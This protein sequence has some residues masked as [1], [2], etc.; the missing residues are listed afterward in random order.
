MTMA[1]RTAFQTAMRAAA[2]EMLTA[3]ALDTGRTLQ[4]YRARPASIF[5]PTAFVDRVHERIAYL[6]PTFIQR[7]PQVDVIV[8]HGLYDSGDA[9][10]QRD[11]FIDAFLDWA[12]DRYHAAGTNTLI[13]VT[14][15]EDDPNYVPDWLPPVNGRQ[16]LYYATL[17]QMEGLALD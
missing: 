3:F 12:V 7:T 2:V 13:A 4:V 15:T 14:T 8:V 1:T 6:G 5:P 9:V 16:S 10:D 17:I 11:A